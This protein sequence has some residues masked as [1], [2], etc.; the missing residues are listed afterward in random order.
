M[1]HEM[2]DKGLFARFYASLWRQVPASMILWLLRVIIKKYQSSMSLICFSCFNVTVMLS[3]H[4]KSIEAPLAFMPGLSQ[5]PD[6]ILIDDQD[7]H[8]PLRRCKPLFSSKLGYANTP[9]TLK[10]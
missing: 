5:A 3:R 4:C 1:L 7:I 2:S 8:I 6:R 9:Y 10:L